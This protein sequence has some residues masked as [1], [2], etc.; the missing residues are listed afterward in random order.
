MAIECFDS[1]G[2]ESRLSIGK[3]GSA[4]YEMTENGLVCSLSFES[5][6]IELDV[7]VELD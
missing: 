1:S 3:D 6:G 5:V 4:V 7:A 2:G